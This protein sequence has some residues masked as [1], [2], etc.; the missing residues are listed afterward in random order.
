MP[1]CDKHARVA[2]IAR[3]TSDSAS[4]SQSSTW[5]GPESP[6]VA[7]ASAPAA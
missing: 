7:K 5:S 2:A 1:T 4:G 3:G 6:G